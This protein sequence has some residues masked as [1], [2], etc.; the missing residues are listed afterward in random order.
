[1]GMKRW[2]DQKGIDMS[3]RR[4]S[5]RS[6]AG[7]IE[8]CNEVLKTKAQRARRRL[9]GIGRRS[10]YEM[11]SLESLVS[12]DSMPTDGGDGGEGQL[13]K[14]RSL[15]SRSTNSPGKYAVDIQGQ[16]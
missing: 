6:G 1:M 4:S 16:D 9:H 12:N 11:Q 3:L 13:R 2:R 10:T 8:E 7:A 15:D 5:I 14:R